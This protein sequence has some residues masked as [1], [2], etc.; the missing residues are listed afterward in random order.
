MN[1]E[2][3]WLFLCG[4]D[5]VI[6]TSFKGGAQDRGIQELQA[7]PTIPKL[8]QG[9]TVTIHDPETSGQPSIELQATNPPPGLEEHKMFYKESSTVRLSA[10]YD[11]HSHPN[12][13]RKEILD[14]PPGAF[15]A[16]SSGLCLTTQ[17]RV[18][19]QYANWKAIVVDGSVVPVGILTVAI[20]ND[21]LQPHAEISGPAWKTMVW[22]NCVKVWPDSQFDYLADFQWNIG[23][24][25]KQS[26]AILTMLK[27]KEEIE[28]WKLNHNEC[29]TQWYTNNASMLKLLSER[30]IGK[31]WISPVNIRNEAEDKI[32]GAQANRWSE[33]IYSSV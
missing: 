20:S 30:C 1:I 16:L 25:C 11:G 4:L 21:L 17:H 31:T 26:Q 15:S 9:K 2:E 28:T 23:Q 32:D 22:A 10:L 33:R 27:D 3:R 13:L 6:Q 14:A 18:A 12:F 19:W 7:Q 24:V 5:G 29:A 8:S